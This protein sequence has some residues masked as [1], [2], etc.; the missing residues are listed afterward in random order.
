MSIESFISKFLNNIPE[1]YDTK[2]N[3]IKKN[4]FLLEYNSLKNYLLCNFDDNSTVAL[5]FEKD[6]R[7]VLSILA[8]MEIGLTYVPLH[9][10]FPNDRVNQIQRITNFDAL[11]DKDLFRKI[12]NSEN[13][14]CHK[15]SFLLN[16]KKNALH[17]VH[18]WE[19]WRTKRRRNK[20]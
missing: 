18:I 19:H 4:Q 20:A 17:N 5:Q 13:K 14:E 7:Y 9:I 11:L 1:I 16:D 6:Y 15:D 8:C 12:I 10:D 2:S 3:L